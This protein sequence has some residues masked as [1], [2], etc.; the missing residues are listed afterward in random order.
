MWRREGVEEGGCGGGRVWRREGGVEEVEE[1][2]RCGP[3]GRA[4]WRE[5]M[6]AVIARILRRSLDW[7]V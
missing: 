1:G 6:Q 4:V 3:G 5:S 2:G 7:V